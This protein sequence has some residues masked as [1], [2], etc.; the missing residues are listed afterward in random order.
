MAT[1]DRVLPIYSGDETDLY[2]Q[3]DGG[4]STK[5]AML[6]VMSLAEM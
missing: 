2:F 4:I 6:I 5:K 3:V 1:G